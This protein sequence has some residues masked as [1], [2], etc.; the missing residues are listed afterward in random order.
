MPTGGCKAVS[1]LCMQWRIVGALLG[2]A[3]ENGGNAGQLTRVVE[4]RGQLLLQADD[5][6]VVVGHL[7]CIQAKHSVAL[8]ALMRVWNQA[9]DLVGIPA[10]TNDE[11][12]GHI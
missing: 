1:R 12:P 8:V 2:C 6:V 7:V 10:Y 5:S 3:C 9:A 4:L 11:V